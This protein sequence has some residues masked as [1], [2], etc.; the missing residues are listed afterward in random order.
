MPNLESNN[1]RP[2]IYSM[3]NVFKIEHNLFLYMYF[4]PLPIRNLGAVV[5]VTKCSPSG[6]H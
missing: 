6:D 5:A 3:H 1:T 4:Y 2:L